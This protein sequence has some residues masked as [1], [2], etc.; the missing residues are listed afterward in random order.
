MYSCD[1]NK[2][3]YPTIY[4]GSTPT[5]KLR[6]KDLDF[7]MSAVQSCHVAFKTVG[8]NSVALKVFEK[9]VIDLTE[10]TISV[11]LSQADTLRFAYGLINV[12]AKLKLISNRVVPTKAT[13]IKIEEILE[14]A[15]L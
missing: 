7:D 13:K 9:P 14:E 10:H 4:R 8:P 2:K 1:C 5:I 6:L 11:E 15:M 3:Q 12:Q